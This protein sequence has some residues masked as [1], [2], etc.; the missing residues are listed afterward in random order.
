MVITFILFA[1][2]LNVVLSESSDKPE[3][4]DS[5]HSVF[6]N[7]L[8]TNQKICSKNGKWCLKHQNDG[9]IIGYSTKDSKPFFSINTIHSNART[10]CSTYTSFVIQSDGNLVLYAKGYILFLNKCSDDYPNVAWASGTNGKGTGPYKLTL[11]DDRNI[12]LK[13]SKNET[14]WS[15]IPKSFL[16]IIQEIYRSF[17]LFLQK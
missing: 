10:D 12:V 2:F 7:T 4:G 3:Y 6:H 11:Q 16:E 9:N 1:I 14:L 8:V 13:D 15:S 17:Y 5:L